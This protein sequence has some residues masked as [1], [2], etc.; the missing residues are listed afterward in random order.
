MKSILICGMLVLVMLVMLS[1]QAQEHHV[2]LVSIDGF[3]P[4]FYLDDEWP[5]PNLKRLAQEGVNAEGVTGVFPSV[6]YP[7]HTTIVTGARPIAHGIYYNTPFE[8][9]GQTGKWYWEA[10]SI[11]VPTLW[12]AVRA[13]GQTSAS[14]LWPVTVGAPID[15]NVPEVWS[16]DKGYDRTQAMR[17]AATD[18][19]LEE[20]E[21]EVTGRIHSKTFNGDYLNRE[22]RIG[23]M[24]AYT[25]ETHKP[26]L[27]ALHLVAT[28]HFQHEQGRDGHKVHTALAASDRAIGKIL[29]AAERADL[30]D[31]LTII[32][33]GDHGFVN[34]HSALSPNVW[35]VEAGLME[36]KKDRGEWKAAFHTAGASAFLMLRNPKDQ[37]T[38]QAVKAKLESLPAAQKKLF[39]VVEREELDAIG[40]DPNAALALAPVP[41]VA[42]SR[43]SG[44]P[45]ITPRSGGTHGYYPDFQQIET[46]FVAWGAGLA[47]SKQLPN[48][49]LEDIA[50]LIS[51]LL[52]LDHRTP[53]GTLYPGVLKED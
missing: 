46:G 20:L 50:P 29:E 30:L 4:D 3:R 16:L 39:R 44:G 23:E 41:G 28:D 22:D 42:M 1:A 19:F 32:V 18:G 24:A 47:A 52:E 33:T 40:A 12:D 38:L 45:V 8:P 34:I 21:R 48:M 2:V 51:H 43:R 26:N 31:K 37:K 6:T 15:Y 36:D 25:L 7:S 13:A 27:M 10:A 11:Q 14:F 49:G 35:L 9:E 5:A 53:H 17:N